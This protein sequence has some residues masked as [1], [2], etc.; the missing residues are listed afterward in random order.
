M[1]TNFDL[2]GLVGQ[3]AAASLPGHRIARIAT[4][5]DVD[6]DGL[7]GIRVVVVLVG[8]DASLS[9]D[10]ALNTIVDLRQALQKAGDDRFPFVDFTNESELAADVDP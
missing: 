6:A 10:E 7:Q 3:V 9:G 4:E 2:D 1:D 5:P 8:D